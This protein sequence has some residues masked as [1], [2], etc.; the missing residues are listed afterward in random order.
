FELLTRRPPFVGTT[1]EVLTAHV[2]AAPPSPRALAPAAGIP[3]EV[4]SL[5]LRALEKDPAERFASAA[6]MDAAIVDVM[7]GRGLGEG[8]AVSR[9][10]C[11][12]SDEAKRSLA[13]WTCFEY[14]RARE[15]ARLAARLDPAWSPLALLMSLVPDH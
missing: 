9:P 12:G 4:E 7:R 15:M 2:G 14:G 10:A 8:E 5:V 1:Y 13:A 11:L 6:A 3:E